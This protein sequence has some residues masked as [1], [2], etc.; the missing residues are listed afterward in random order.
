MIIAKILGFLFPSLFY[1][2]VMYGSPVE[3]SL[4]RKFLGFSGRRKTKIGGSNNQQ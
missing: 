2:G 1:F 3:N 4:G